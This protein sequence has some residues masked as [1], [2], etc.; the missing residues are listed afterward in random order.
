V[1]TGLDADIFTHP[2]NLTEEFFTKEEYA[3]LKQQI[4]KAALEAAQKIDGFLGYAGGERSFEQA[5][6]GFC[7]INFK[8]EPSV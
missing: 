3:S 1:F 4:E 8:G 6:R 7:D 5:V 2:K